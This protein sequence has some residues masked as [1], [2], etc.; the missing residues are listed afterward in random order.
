MKPRF[1]CAEC[2]N[3]I[4]WGAQVCPSCGKPVEWPEEAAATDAGGAASALVACSKCGSENAGDADFCGSCGAKLKL[5]GTIASGRQQSG[6]ARLAPK[7]GKVPAQKKNR[8]SSGPMFSWK[9]IFGFLGVLLILV[10]VLEFYPSRDQKTSQV[11]ST[12]PRAPAANLQLIDQIT[13]LEKRVAANPNDLQS[14]LTLA[15]VCQDGRFFDKAIV[16]YRKYLEKSPRDANAR[17]D[18]G[19]C[20]FETSNLEEARKEM[21]TALKHDSKHVAA[22]FNLGIVSLR[23]GKVKEA[24]DW[25]KK[26]IALA[27]TSDMGRQAKQILEQHSSPLLQNK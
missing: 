24:N 2:Q 22:H 15:N 11:T 10:V 14:L 9:V 25:F 4:Q 20:Y 5:Q 19:I 21:E 16:Q 27:P 7:Q 3:E 13:D 8:E 17:V 12:T 23:A 18:M 1:Q 26:T 6:H